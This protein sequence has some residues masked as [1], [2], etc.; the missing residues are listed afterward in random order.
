MS[1]E[2]YFPLEPA[3]F[4]KR[5]HHSKSQT[6]SQVFLSTNNEVVIGAAQ[7]P[8]KTFTSWWLNHPFEKY[9]CQIGS[10]PLVSG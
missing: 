9:A 8:F 3:H 5:E 10:F 4:L 1:S 7:F 2:A 6:F